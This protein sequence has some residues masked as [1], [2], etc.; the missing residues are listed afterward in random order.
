MPIGARSIG[1]MCLI[2]IQLAEVG[3]KRPLH[4]GILKLKGRSRASLD[5]ANVPSHFLRYSVS[6]SQS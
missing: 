4:R 2:G 6:P 1:M 5:K 3:Q